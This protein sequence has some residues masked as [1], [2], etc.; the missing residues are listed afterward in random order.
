MRQLDRN[1]VERPPAL[2][3]IARRIKVRGVNANDG[4]VFEVRHE[5]KLRVVPLWSGADQRIDMASTTIDPS[6]R[7]RRKRTLDRAALLELPRLR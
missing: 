1:L 6:P 3:S 7:R 5:G 4:D 2:A